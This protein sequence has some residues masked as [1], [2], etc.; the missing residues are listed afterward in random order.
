M[1]DTE[2]KVIN[3]LV[4]SARSADPAR[5]QTHCRTNECCRQ[6]R[7][8][9]ATAGVLVGTRGRIES[10]YE[11]SPPI[12]PVAIFCEAIDAR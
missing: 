8:A 3:I 4:K 1:T 10:M 9:E 7:N 5:K 2:S 11:N 12:C 6:E